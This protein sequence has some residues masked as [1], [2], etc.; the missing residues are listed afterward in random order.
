L[1]EIRGAR[2]KTRRKKMGSVDY[3]KM[4][5]HR[6]LLAVMWDYYKTKFSE[7]NDRSIR[8]FLD[9]LALYLIETLPIFKGSATDIVQQ[10]FAGSGQEFCPSPKLPEE[11]AT[12]AN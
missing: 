3:V 12:S 7:S 8:V 6:R 10:S 2:Q 4:E 5:K 11:P 1:Y 9:N